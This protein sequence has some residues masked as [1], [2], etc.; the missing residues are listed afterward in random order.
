MT[1]I[2]LLAPAK[3]LSCGKAAVEHGADAVYMGGPAFGARVAAG[4]TMADIEEMARHAHR[5]RARVYLTI[6][7]ILYDDELDAAADLARQ[8]W[9]AGV[10]GLI[11]QDLGL[12][13][14]ELPPLPLIA[15]TQMH[16]AEA[17]HVR[18]LEQ[19]GFQRAILAR[20]LSLEQIRNVRRSTAAIELETFVHGA[21]CVSYSGRCYLS[22]SLGGRS[23]NRGACGQP[24]RLPWDLVGESGLPLERGRHLLCLKDMDRSAFLAELMDAGVTAFKI[25]GR[26]KD[27]SYVKNITALYRSHIDAVLE[28]RPGF[29]RSSSGRTE[30]SFTPDPRKTFHRGATEYFLHGEDD[31]VWSP[32]TPKSLG[33][34]L[35]PVMR[36]GPNWFTLVRGAADIT[37]GDGLCFLDVQGELQGLQV[38]KVSSDR[39]Q[40]HQMR[41]GMMPGARVFRNRNHAFLKQLDGDTAVR[42]VDLRLVFSET[43]EGFLLEG[44]DEDGIRATAT[45]YTEKAPADKAEA[46]MD[47]ILRQ[48]SKLAGTMFR[49]VS[50]EIRSRP[51]FLRTA[52][53]NE[54]RRDLMAAMERARHTSYT[55]PLRG[56][57]PGPSAVYPETRLDYAYNISNRRARAFYR[58]HGVS[59]L[60]AAFELLPKTQGMVV[61]TTKHCIRRSL[62]ACLRKKS[63]RDLPEPLFIVHGDRRFR[64]EFDCRSCCMRIVA[65]GEDE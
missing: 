41:A 35:G 24:C 59:S 36:C 53:L 20:E 25:E 50:L 57:A 13:E 46:A 60:E 38:V 45:L 10:D 3:D 32:D 17:A 37:A 56:P 43:D 64:V 47:T 21:L 27:I 61:M 16:N 2:E 29:S 49:P 28:E 4:N 52:Q 26:L 15:S 42:K 19:V 62:S 33:E 54:L 6:N 39:I 55:R 40:V 30:F 18:F 48:L 7:T 34:E 14:L 8:A 63:L 1:R 65:V 31:H 23:A 51:Y 12:L 22:A 58:T 5:Y 11:I 9:D 44:T